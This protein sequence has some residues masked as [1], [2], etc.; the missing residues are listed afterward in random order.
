MS[1]LTTESDNPKKRRWAGWILMALSLLGGAVYGLHLYHL[2]QVREVTDNA[3]IS[4]DIT[5]ISPGLVD[6]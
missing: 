4:A 6:R 1:N 5:R 2:S 3:Q